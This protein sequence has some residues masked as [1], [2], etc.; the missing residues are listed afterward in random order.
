MERSSSRASVS[1]LA[2]G[3]SSGGLHADICGDD[4]R[5]EFV[6]RPVAEAVKHFPA[7]FPLGADVPAGKI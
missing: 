1:D 7:F 4:V 2:A 5:N 3:R 6:K